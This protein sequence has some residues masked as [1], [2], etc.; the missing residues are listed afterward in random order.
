MT[1]YTTTVLSVKAFSEF[2]NMLPSGTQD[3]SYFIDVLDHELP[4]ISV[5]IALDDLFDWNDGMYEFNPPGRLPLFGA[6]FWQPWSR[7]ARMQGFDALGSLAA[8]EEL[9]ESMA[10]GLA[11]PQNPSDL[12]SRV[13]T[14]FGLAVVP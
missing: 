1:A 14:G 6:N 10:A 12:I 13:H 4:V 2:N 9:T 7:H 11:E 5:L 8:R 3:E